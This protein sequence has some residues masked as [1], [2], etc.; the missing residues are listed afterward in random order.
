MILLMNGDHDLK[1]FGGAISPCALW[2]IGVV[3]FA[4]RET[5]TK[6]LLIAP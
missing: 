4:F 3:A 1:S 2:G 5:T 6:A